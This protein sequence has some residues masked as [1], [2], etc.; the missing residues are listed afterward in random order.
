MF[1]EARHVFFCRLQPENLCLI[2]DEHCLWDWF[3]T[4]ALNQ[5]KIEKN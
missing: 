1:F 4:F 3:I 2:Q 5:K